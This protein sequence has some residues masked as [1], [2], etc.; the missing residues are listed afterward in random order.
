[1]GKITDDTT[2]VDM[3]SPCIRLHILHRVYL[4]QPIFEIKEGSCRAGCNLISELNVEHY[5]MQG[6]FQMF[7]YFR[8]SV[9]PKFISHS[10]SWTRKY[11]NSLEDTVYGIVKFQYCTYGF[12]GIAEEMNHTL[13]YSVITVP[14]ELYYGHIVSKTHNTD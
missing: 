2:F 11:G 1:M 4:I 12:W 14:Q 13:L 3:L 5:R 9:S 8:H 10:Q 7:L 6:P